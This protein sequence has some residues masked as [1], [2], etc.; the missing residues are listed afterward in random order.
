M[1][2]NFEN[3]PPEERIK[4][5]REEEKKKQK[6]IDDARKKIKE[7]EDE[8]TE[9]RKWEDKVPIPEFMA[10]SLEGLSKDAQDMIRSQKGI[11][12]KEN[13]DGS[14]EELQKETNEGNKEKIN[15]E[16]TLNSENFD[17]NV[18]VNHG[19]P[20]ANM[21]GGFNH[22]PGNL[23]YSPLN[24]LQDQVKSVYDSVK[25]KG[26]MN[27][28]EQKK[29]VDVNSAIDD[30]FRAYDAGQYSLS[31]AAA[32]AAMMTRKLTGRLLD[33]NYQAKK[34]HDSHQKD[35]YKS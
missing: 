5:F 3:L 35:W 30:K 18:N 12:K 1:T 32:N 34:S 8:L 15:L 24:E 14:E 2:K 4:K 20:D 10:E 25:E 17:K 27:W 22:Q 16:K 21:P 9:R 23:T 11:S 28:E 29:V 7:S 26:Y 33:D 19:V 31:E 6:E 13:F